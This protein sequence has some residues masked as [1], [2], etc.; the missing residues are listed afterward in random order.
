MEKHLVS[1]CIVAYNGAQEVEQAV[2]SI[3]AN[4]PS[5]N[6]TFYVVDNA[7][8]DKSGEELQQAFSEAQQVEV[9]CLP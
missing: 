7:S 4:S 3:L 8:P 2:R 6:L 1:A 9:I 5:C